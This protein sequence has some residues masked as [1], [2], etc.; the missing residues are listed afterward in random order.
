MS[1]MI[2]LR[3]TLATHIYQLLVHLRF[4]ALVGQ[5]RRRQLM[6]LRSMQLLG[7]RLSVIRTSLIFGQVNLALSSRMLIISKRVESWPLRL[8]LGESNKFKSR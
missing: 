4:S 3:N 6:S 2:F 7:A 8:S 1:S 5:M